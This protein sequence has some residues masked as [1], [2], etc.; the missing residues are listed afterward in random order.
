MSLKFG[1][2]ISCRHLTILKQYS[3]SLADSS[4]RGRTHCSRMTSAVALA[5]EMVLGNQVLA[6]LARRNL[7]FWYSSMCCFSSSMITLILVARSLF[8]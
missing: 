6:C 3:E 4:N 7:V 1:A 5:L 2:R 8:F